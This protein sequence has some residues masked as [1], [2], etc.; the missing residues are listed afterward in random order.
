MGKPEFHNSNRPATRVCSDGTSPSSA[1]PISA[2]FGR[3]LYV[4]DRE[5]FGGPLLGSSFTPTLSSA[6]LEHGTYRG[7][8]HGRAYK[9]VGNDRIAS[10]AWLST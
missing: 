2:V 6:D 4:I 7:P 9:R 3:P 10:A 1:H 5:E 8:S